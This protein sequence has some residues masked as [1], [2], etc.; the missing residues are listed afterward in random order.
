MSQCSRT[1]SSSERQALENMNRKDA[2]FWQPLLR[3]NT[4][5]ED[6]NHYWR[7]R[8]L[9][10]SVHSS[11]L[12]RPRHWVQPQLQEKYKEAPQKY[13]KAQHLRALTRI[14]TTAAHCFGALHMSQFLQDGKNPWIISTYFNQGGQ[15]C[16][17]PKYANTYT[18]KKSMGGNSGNFCI[19][20]NVC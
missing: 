17:H 14:S 13:N 3:E 18:R 1:N 19:F 15:M 9:C 8:W 7:D 16:P 10:R 5:T 6:T 11:A 20:L 12:Q 4:T 2:E